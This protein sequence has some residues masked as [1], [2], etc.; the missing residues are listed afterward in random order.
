M[1]LRI[2]LFLD[3]L[4]GGGAARVA[5]YLTWAWAEAGRTVT[6]LTLDEGAL[7]PFFPLHPSIIHR[8]L[9]TRRPSRNLLEAIVRNGSNLTQLRRAISDSQPDVLVSF[10]SENNVKA[11]LATRGL[12]RIPIIISERTDPHGR[13]IG[14]V[15]ENLR[16]LT[17]SWSDVLVVQTQHALQYFAPKVRTKGVVIPNPV[18]P[19]AAHSHACD[20][21]PHT[22]FTVVTFGS[23]RAVKGHDMLIEAFRRVAS[24]F[25]DWDLRIFGEGQD[26]NALQA[27]IQACG[28]A[29]RIFLPGHIS[30]EHLPE[31]DLFVLPSRAEGFPNALAE[32]MARGLPVISF[33]CLSGPL[34]LIR[35][36]LD[37][38][39][40]PPEDIEALSGA[41]ARLMAAPEER[42][43]LAARAPEVV[44]RFSLERILELW[45]GALQ[46]A[47]VPSG[48]NASKRERIQPCSPE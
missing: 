8:P 9:N 18:L 1:P 12:R 42:A 22:R 24:A 11:L 17:Y 33:D 30:L 27:Q 45:E 41:M 25:P 47:C 6:I 16:R 38:I 31:A 13:S 48:P 34:E 43:R 46:S 3:D 23:L 44:E 7:P 4:L 10:L 37:G 21:P 36:G 20:D 26:R 35:D 15:W 14:F 19:G 5:S 39:L 32:A 28:L 29:E 40:V 2:T